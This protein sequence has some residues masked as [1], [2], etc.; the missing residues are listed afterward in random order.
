MT[1]PNQTALA[2]GVLVL[3]EVVKKSYFPGQRH[4]G[5]PRHRPPIFSHPLK[6]Y[7][8]VHIFSHV[9]VDLYVLLFYLREKS[10]VRRGYE[11]PRVSG[12]GD[13]EGVWG[14]GS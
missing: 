7:E 13:L 3:G 14:S 1:L 8:I 10:T 6:G 11:D 5:G 4:S 12:K 9:F 2:Q